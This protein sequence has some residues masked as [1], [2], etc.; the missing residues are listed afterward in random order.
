MSKSLKKETRIFIW[1]KYDCKCAYCGDSLP[2]NKMQ[3]DHIEPRRRGDT[4]EYLSTIGIVRGKNT[5]ENYNPSCGSCNSSKSTFTLD[6]WRNELELKQSRLLRDSSTFRI[7][8]RFGLI[9]LGANK[10]TY[11]FEKK[12]IKL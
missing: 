12:G 11:H 5:L 3:V 1:N 7:L 8:E 9:K 4:T 10:V 2:Y 6:Q